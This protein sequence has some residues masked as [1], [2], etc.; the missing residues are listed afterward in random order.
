MKH[1]TI[2]I[3]LALFLGSC[4]GDDF[5]DD[6]V[7]PVLRINNPIDSLAVGTDYQFLVSY[8]NNVGKEESNDIVWSSNNEEVIAISPSG[9]ATAISPGTATLEALTQSPEGEVRRSFEVAAG[10]STVEAVTSTIRT[11]AIRTTTFYDL[12]GDFELIT[13]DDGSLELAIA[14]NYLASSSLPGLYLYLTN[15]PRTINGAFE[16]GKVDVFSGAHSYN[17]EGVEINDYNY[18]LYFCKPF[19]VKVGDGEIE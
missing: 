11:G 2:A 6:R 8:F 4:V 9:L 12:Q 17:I 15:N 3:L 1:I 7:D 13:N 16:V 14:D 5:I 18:L 10:A 19:N